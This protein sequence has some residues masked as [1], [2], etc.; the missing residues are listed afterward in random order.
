MSTTRNF[1]VEVHTTYWQYAGCTASFESARK[2]ALRKA[3]EWR[4][5]ARVLDKNVP[6]WACVYNT[7]SHPEQ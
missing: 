2:L 6:G 3:D 4:S 1:R 7:E 5:S